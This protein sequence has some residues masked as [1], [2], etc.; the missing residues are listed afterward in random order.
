MPKIVTMSEF[1]QSQNKFNFGNYVNYVDR[2]EAQKNEHEVFQYDVYAHYMFDEQKSNSM[3]NNN[4]NYMSKEEIDYTKNKF[5]NAQ[6]DNGIMWKDVISF[7]NESLKEAG[8]YDPDCKYLDEQKMRQATRKSM[9]KFEKKEGLDNNLVW[10]SSI[11]YN[12]DNIHVHVAAVENEVTRERGKRKYSTI[13][14]MKSSFANELFDMSGER[15]KINNFIRDNIVKGIKEEKEPDYNLEMKNQLKKIHDEVKDIPKKEWQYN[16]NIMKNAR[17][18]IDKFTMMYIKNNHGEE[19]DQFKSDL[20]KQ[21]L[22]Y[23]ETYGDK[24]D[25]KNYE[26]TKMNDLYS[27]AGNTVLKQLKNFNEE[28]N[29]IKYKQNDKQETKGNKPQIN[30]TVKNKMQIG[31]ALNGT[32]YN[33]QRALRNDFQKEKNINDYH[34]EF[35]KSYQQE[36]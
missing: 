31:Y 17:P 19:F 24:S 2:E 15:A 12:T 28:Y 20:K 23:K 25:Y 26:A 22:L 33:T 36:L 1:E 32:L 18:E 6:K 30:P 11:H 21:T 16:N 35:D 3:F 13:K 4:S 29:N 7:D 34:F 8:I 14:E 10:A 27:R 9:E 5:N